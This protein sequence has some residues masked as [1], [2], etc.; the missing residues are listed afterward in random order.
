MPLKEPHYHPVQEI[1]GLKA[2]I[3]SG[4][5]IAFG[6]TGSVAI[7]RSVDVVREL[8]RR[9]AEVYTVLSEAATELT[10]PTLFE[11][12]TGSKAFTGFAG[13]TGHVALGK[14]CDSMVIAPATADI[15]SKIAYGICDNP[16]SLT[17]VDMLGL[18]KPL[19]IAPAMHRGLWRS[20]PII[21]AVRKLEKFD[22]TIIPPV[23]LEGKAK[24][25]S[26]DDIVAA[27]EAITLR[28]KD[29]K[30]LKVLVTAGPTREY[31]DNVRFLSNPSTGKMGVSI[32]R[33]AFFRGAQV[34]LVHGPLSV[35]K[36]HYIRSIGV[37][38]TEEM[39]QAIAKEV[40]TH[41]YDAIIMAAAPA[42]F[43]FNRKFS[44]K[45]R[46]ESGPINVTLEPT[47]KIAAE[48]RKHFEGLLVGFAAECVAGN[49]NA[50]A[51]AAHHKMMERGFNIIVANDVCSEGSGFATE[52]NE[53]LIIVKGKEPKHVK[54]TLKS[55]V[56]RRI[57]DAVRDEIYAGGHNQSSSTR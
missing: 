5:K 11:W 53:V 2:S 13:E 57:M 55:E 51:E 29:L 46:T 23:D 40:S 41:K 27:V 42:D 38:T 16:V 43:K 1:E 52:T 50:L 14:T 9:G 30:G 24:Y 12:A 47:P 31:L 17:A 10:S 35:S 25:P 44:G 48:V 36:P 6:L 19:I 3:L 49:M 20:P 7:Y 54:L 15:L 18:S 32:A 21:E 39:L 26:L 37:E 34:T 45:V 28:G 56:A 33:E 4:R 22:V 8:I